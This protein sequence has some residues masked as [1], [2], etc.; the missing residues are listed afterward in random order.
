MKN[1]QFNIT[2]I[3]SLGFLLDLKFDRLKD[4]P[5]PGGD[6]PYLPGYFISG[7]SHQGEEEKLWA[8]HSP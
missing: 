6:R 1:N 2:I 7:T 8:F 3:F 4:A 5:G